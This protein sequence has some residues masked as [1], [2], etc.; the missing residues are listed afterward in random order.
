[1]EPRCKGGTA[2][3]D[4]ADQAIVTQDFGFEIAAHRIKA[5]GAEFL[6][7][8]QRLIGDLALGLAIKLEPQGELLGARQVATEID[9]VALRVEALRVELAESA[10]ETAH[11][12]DDACIE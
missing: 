12:E 11:M 4:R 10:A 2:K 6:G 3:L 1:M 9:K 7:T 5:A 8:N